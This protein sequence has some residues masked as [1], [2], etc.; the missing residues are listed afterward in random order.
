MKEM[1]S[2]AFNMGYVLSANLSSLLISVFIAL[3]VPRLMGVSDYG[4]WELYLF[5]SSYAGFFHLGWADGILLRFGG[6]DY[7]SLDASVFSPMNQWFVYFQAMILVILSSYLLIVRPENTVIYLAAI[8][9]SVM[10]NLRSYNTFIL[11][12]T[13]RMKEFSA[14]I[15]AGNL[16]F[17]V[18]L[19]SIFAFNVS[20]ETLILVDLISKLLSLM[21][22]FFLTHELSFM[23]ASKYPKRL[24]RRDSMKEIQ[25]TITAGLPLT[26]AYIISLLMTGI[27]RFAIEIRWGIAD[28]AQISLALNISS[29][30]LVFVSAIGISVFPILKQIPEA[31]FKEIFQ[32]VNEWLTFA[33]FLTAS[34]FYL[35]RPL[36]VFWLPRY[37]E[38]IN[39]L[40]YLFPIFIFQSKNALLVTTFLKALRYEKFIVQQNLITVAISLVLAF[41][42]VE[43]LGQIEAVVVCILL[44]N[45]FLTIFGEWR[46]NRLFKLSFGV[47]VIKE[48][49]ATL[50]FIVMSFYF[51]MW[52]GFCLYVLTV[53][54]IF[55][56]NLNDLKLA[57]KD[58]S[59]PGRE[60]ED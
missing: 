7:R 5:Y 38:G 27:Y 57:I 35:G 15:F 10:L 54:F 1:K 4:L 41:I 45:A 25:L 17:I 26:I 56:P 30:I 36:L 9:L 16:A 23:S 42:S 53:L 18:G 32:T 20:F 12:A 19:A 34:L 31:Y 14:V 33:L 11:Q 50:S 49:L 28:F 13:N 39:Y 40:T 59:I 48:V 51:N 6:R 8:L 29:F 55:R 22:S 47:L 21:Y 46:M 37:A 43:L 44:S 2:L 60:E 52:L 58:L 24:N 3:F